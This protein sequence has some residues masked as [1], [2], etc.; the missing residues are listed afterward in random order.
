MTTA[1]YRRSLHF[2][3]RDECLY[4]TALDPILPCGTGVLARI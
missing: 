2:E 3:F 4:N 1:S